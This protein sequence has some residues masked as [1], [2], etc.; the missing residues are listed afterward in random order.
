MTVDGL[1]NAVEEVD[2]SG[3]PVGPDNPYGNALVQEVTRLRTEGEA[4]RRCDASRG[5]TWRVISTEEVNRFG[6]PVS[7][8][9]YPEAAPALLADPASSLAARAGFAANHLWVTQYDPAQRYPA[10]DFVNQHPGGAGLPAFVAGDRDID[11]TDIVLWHTFGPTHFPRPEEWPVMPAA[12]C[13]FMLKPTGFFGR[14]PTLDVPPADR[15]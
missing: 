15:C 9:L 11:G 4:G 8:T 7:Y 1:A 14:N 5:R 3:R 13:G 10:G 12:R 6:V 2:V